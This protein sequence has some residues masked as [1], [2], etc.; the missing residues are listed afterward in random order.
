[1]NTEKLTN[2]IGE[3]NPVGINAGAGT[4]PVKAA[5][6]YAFIVALVAA[7]GG[8][9]FGYD[10]HIITASQ[11]FWRDY[12]KLSDAQFG[13]AMSSAI[14]GCIVGPFT[15]GWLADKFG[16]RGTLIFAGALFGL[17]AIGTGLARTI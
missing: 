4:S 13:F 8:L 3:T 10:L 1:M 11:I 14:L 9:L 12:F 16:R 17:S 15:G 2:A 5:T 7:V 6:G